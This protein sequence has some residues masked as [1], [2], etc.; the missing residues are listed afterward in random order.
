MILLTDEE[1]AAIIAAEGISS[2][3]YN[4]F[5]TDFPDRASFVVSPGHLSLMEFEWGLFTSGLEAECANI[6][7][8]GVIRII[9]HKR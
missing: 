5:I 6:D 2:F 4:P 7:V 8:D 9:A 1:Y 3:V